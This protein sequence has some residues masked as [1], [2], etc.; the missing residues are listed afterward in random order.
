MARGWA[1]V[2]ITKLGGGLNTIAAPYELAG[3]ESPNLLNVRATRRGSVRKRPGLLSLGSADVDNQS[4]PEQ[5]RRI[6]VYRTDTRSRAIAITKDALYLHPM[7]PG[8]S[9]PAAPRTVEAPWLWDWTQAPAVDNQGPLFL[10]GPQSAGGSLLF[11][12]GTTFGVWSAAPGS[13]SPIPT[14]KVMCTHQTRVFVGA[15]TADYG[16]IESPLSTMVWSDAMNS[17]VWDTDRRKLTFEPYRGAEITAMVSYRD[18]LLVFSR[19]SIWRV[20]DSATGANSRV[21]AEAGTVF[22]DSVVVTDMGVFFLDPDRGVMVTDGMDVRLASDAIL[23][24]L[25]GIPLDESSRYAVSGAFFDR[26]YFLSVPDQS[27]VPSRMFEYNTRDKTWWE[28]DCAAYDLAVTAFPDAPDLSLRQDTMVGALPERFVKSRG[29]AQERPHRLVQLFRPGAMADEFKGSNPKPIQFRWVSAPIEFT[30]NPHLA[31]R[32]AGLRIDNLGF[33]QVWQIRDHSNA[34]EDLGETP[35]GSSEPRRW[36]QRGE[37]LWQQNLNGYLWR[38]GV[39]SMNQSRFF[40]LG[41]ARVW[42]LRVTGETMEEF[43]LHSYSV[44]IGPKMGKD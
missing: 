41:R 11:Y 7:T 27:G 12:D 14:G 21:G 36:R 25:Q 18:N 20:Y 15:L 6:A 30:G 9:P 42:Q 44:F 39:S 26:S 38:G 33:S 16:S 10:M 13:P 1:Q 43:E 2:N 34:P 8:E 23:P 24:E 28:H 37:R 19:D 40:T 17:R 4:Y 32:I 35:R 3:D 29:L 22:R 5:V 31:K